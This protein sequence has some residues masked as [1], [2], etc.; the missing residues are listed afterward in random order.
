MGKNGN[1]TLS[2][3]W[4]ASHLLCFPVNAFSLIM[5][6]PKQGRSEASVS[7]MAGNMDIVDM[8]FIDF[9]FLWLTDGGS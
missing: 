1:G 5:V 7:W 2:E 3:C 4:S 9:E 6:C 8:S